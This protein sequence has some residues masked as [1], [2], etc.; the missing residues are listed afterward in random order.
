M[1]G[2][3]PRPRGLRTADRRAEPVPRPGLANTAR[4]PVSPPDSRRLPGIYSGSMGILVQWEEIR[5]V[6]T[7]CAAI[8][9]GL[10][11]LA[12]LVELAYPRYLAWRDTRTLHITIG[13]LRLYDK[14]EI[15]RAARF[16]V[17]PDCQSVDPGGGEDFRQV[18]PTREPLFTKADRVFED[19]RRYKFFFLLADSGTGKTSFL[20]NYYARHQRT[21]R[22]RNLFRLALIPLNLPNS[23]DL[24]NKIPQEERHDIVLMLDALDEDQ[25]AVEDHASRIN[26]LVRLTVDFRSVLI[27]CRTQFF[28]KDEEIPVSLGMIVTKIGPTSLTKQKRTHFTS[29]ISPH[30]LTSK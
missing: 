26:E 22:R 20:L 19:R 9:G 25:Q 27:T 24:I 14:Q 1:R 8:L 21:R 12:K 2:R 3:S 11:G 7:T 6:A 28:P 4:I 23:D 15:K 29:F 13:K 30:L 17:A 18:V 10:A 5:L 16:Y